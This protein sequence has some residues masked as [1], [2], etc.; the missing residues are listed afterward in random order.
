M[1]DD[2][3]G[4]PIHNKRIHGTQYAGALRRRVE[5]L[6]SLGNTILAEE[7][8]LRSADVVERTAEVCGWDWKLAEEGV[9]L[10]MEVVGKP[11]T[12]ESMERKCLEIASTWDMDV[13]FSESCRSRGKTQR[14]IERNFRLRSAMPNASMVFRSPEH[15]RFF[16]G[17]ITK[18][19][20]SFG[21]I[22]TEALGDV[23]MDRSS[24][25]SPGSWQDLQV[26]QEVVFMVRHEQRGPHALE[27]ELVS[28]T[29]YGQMA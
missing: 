10:L 21:F 8:A 1:K 2:D 6:Y 14:V 13:K 18:I 26:G 16:K 12:S 7:V 3:V 29:N 27:L 19:I 9:Q 22:G 24:L 11:G 17:A 28:E 25:V 5:Q 15:A 20:G 23:H 4:V